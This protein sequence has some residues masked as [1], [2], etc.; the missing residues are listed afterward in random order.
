MLKTSIIIASY[1]RAAQLAVT[2]RRLPVKPMQDFGAELIL[3]GSAPDDATAAVFKQY[4]DTVSFPVKWA[5][6]SDPGFV[7]AQN[8]GISMSDG[9]LIVFTDDDCYMDENY[10]TILHDKF[11]PKVFQYGSGEIGR[12]SRDYD[13]GVAHTEWWSFKE[14]GA[15]LRPR[16]FISPG[17][18]QG[19]NMFFLREVLAAT[20]G[21][22]KVGPIDSNDAMTAHLASQAGY[23]GVM[24]RGPK[25]YHDHGRK[26]NTPEAEHVKDMYAVV[27]GAYFAQLAASGG[28]DFFQ[29]WQDRLP[30]PSDTTELRR[31]GLALGAFAEE[32]AWMQEARA[33][34]SQNPH[35]SPRFS[36]TLAKA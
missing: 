21:V 19:A 11:D 24:L 18:I 8:V 15:I 1:K 14:E 23:T 5:M 13:W 6:A 29:Y 27:T 4:G 36:Y 17:F 10:L 2:L 32:I 31:L 25:V 28:K 22:R 3:V 12:A 34:Q 26:A 35:Y 7:H 9:D 16:S 33:T 20:G 30:E